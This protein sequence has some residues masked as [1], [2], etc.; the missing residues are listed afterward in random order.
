VTRPQ[1]GPPRN[2]DSVR[3]NNIFLLHEFKTGSGTQPASY[4]IRTG[5][6]GPEERG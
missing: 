2:L 5:A 3:T 6:L 1:V 4:P